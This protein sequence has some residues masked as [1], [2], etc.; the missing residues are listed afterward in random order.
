VILIFLAVQLLLIGYVFYQSYQGRADVVYNARRGCERGKLDRNAN[1][2]GWRIA[3]AARRHDGQ[4]AVANK[5]A[6]IASGQEKRSR[7]NCNK[8]YPKAG[9]FP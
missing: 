7:I 2:E 1:A 9:V 5:Y 4:I 3:E 6:R 8:A